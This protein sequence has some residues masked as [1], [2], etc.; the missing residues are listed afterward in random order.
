MLNNL[1]GLA[2]DPVVQFSS[3]PL[4]ADTFFKLYYLC[5]ITGKCRI[6]FTIL[7]KMYTLGNIYVK[8]IAKKKC[9]GNVALRCL[10]KHYMPIGLVCC[11]AQRAHSL[12]WGLYLKSETNK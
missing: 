7:L 11:S 1:H 3:V 5:Y 9:L 6:N 2:W 4:G 12:I 8:K 10:K